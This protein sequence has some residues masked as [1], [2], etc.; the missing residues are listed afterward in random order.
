M[1]N[2]L[3]IWQIK[4]LKW[5]KVNTAISGLKTKVSGYITRTSDQLLSSA[6]E[7]ENNRVRQTS[8][9]SS[10]KCVA[11]IHHNPILCYCEAFMRME[12]YYY[13]S[14]PSVF[15]RV[16]L[17]WD[18]WGF[19]SRRKKWAAWWQLWVMAHFS[20]LG[21]RARRLAEDAAFLSRRFLC[22]ST[23]PSFSLFLRTLEH[24]RTRISFL[25]FPEVNTVRVHIRTL[26]STQM[27]AVTHYLCMQ[28]G[29]LWKCCMHK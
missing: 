8:H 27:H 14:G 25:S 11:F 24:Q 18:M 16:S 9:T 22:L 4:W 13:S 5:K 29:N 7:T 20:R 10:C 21:E 19:S 26:N 1:L 15:Q 2:I 6:V 3:C 17:W 28:N 12:F 23:F